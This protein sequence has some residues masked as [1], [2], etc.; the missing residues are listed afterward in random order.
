MQKQ[1]S[2]QQQRK[3]RLRSHESGSWGSTSA[4]Y[5]RLVAKLFH[6]SAVTAASAIHDDWVYAGIPML[7][8]G[9]EAFLIE[10]Q[11]ILNQNPNRST[12][13]GDDPIRDVLLLYSLPDDLRDDMSALIEIRNQIVHPSPVPFGSYYWPAS[14]ERLRS[15]GVLDGRTPQSGADVLSILASHRLFEWAVEKCARTLDVI[16]ASDQDRA[17]MFHSLADNLWKVLKH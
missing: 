16:S 11:R 15:Q 6:E 12:I 8:T 5:F 9:V 17:W 3:A 2:E 10:H 7:V 13:A 4:T 14:L 1:K